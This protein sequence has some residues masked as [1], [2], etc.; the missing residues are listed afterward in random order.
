MKVFLLLPGNHFTCPVLPPLLPCPFASLP[1]LSA[2]PLTWL[3]MSMEEQGQGHQC[4]GMR[5]NHCALTHNKC[6]QKAKT[7]KHVN[8][9]PKYCDTT[10]MLG[11]TPPE[12]ALNGGHR[13]PLSSLCSSYLRPPGRTISREEEGWKGRREER[14]DLICSLRF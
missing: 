7:G 4:L 13:C 11:C 6:I 8:H 12:Q 10:C 9:P 1:P 2:S 3:G 14:T 5:S